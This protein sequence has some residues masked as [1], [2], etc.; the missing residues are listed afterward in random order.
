MNSRRGH[1]VT[2]TSAA[3]VTAGRAASTAAVARSKAMAR[4]ALAT[5]DIVE[6]R[7]A[8]VRPRSL[9]PAHVR[10]VAARLIGAYRQ[11]SPSSPDST[12]AP[13]APVDAVRTRDTFR[14]A[15]PPPAR[16]VRRRLCGPA[17]DGCASAPPAAPDAAASASAGA[18]AS[19]AAANAPPTL[20]L[21][22]LLRAHTRAYAPPFLRHGAQ[23]PPRRF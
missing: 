16:R 6:H 20:E 18:S 10:N 17:A 13:R 12:L 7:G 5:L 1:A 15:S 11:H 14:S 8:S 22:A 23:R 21:S 4:S 19:P 2:A 3:A 9:S